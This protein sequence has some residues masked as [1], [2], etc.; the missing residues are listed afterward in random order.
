[1][2][3][4]IAGRC[5]YHL[6]SGLKV[7]QNA[8][9][10]WLTL[11]SNAI[12]TLISRRHP[13]TPRLSYIHHLT[14]AARDNPGNCCLLGLGGAGVAHAL[15]PYL[16]KLQLIAVESSHEVIETAKKY[17]MTNCLEN[18]SI[19][20]QDAN[21]FVQR[22]TTCYQHLLIDIFDAYSFP[23]HCNN[24]C[25]FNNCRNRLLPDGI[26]AVNLANLQEQGPIFSIIREL[27]GNRTIALPVKGTANMI[28]LACN[29]DS[30]LPLLH[31][32]KNSRDL[33]KLVWDERWGYIAQL[34]F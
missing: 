9:Y 23:A 19:I 31:L 12:Q 18:L 27:F 14:L 25:F 28:I 13:E 1:M 26:L 29:N 17:F 6:P 24:L 2:W 5:I 32:I 8:L 20:H 30:V 16:N 11:G 4:T 34:N 33:K 3:K 10:R 15:S 7:H 21:L 22:D